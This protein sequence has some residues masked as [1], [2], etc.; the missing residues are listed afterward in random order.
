M[1]ERAWVLP[2]AI[3]SVVLFLVQASILVFMVPPEGLRIAAFAS[4]S[5]LGFAYMLIQ[6]PVFEAWKERHWPE[7]DYKPNALG[8]LF[9][10]AILC[11]ALEVAVMFGFMAANNEM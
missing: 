1:G 7:G 2:T 8:L 5:V 9:S 6:K 10:T 11:V 4:N 3:A